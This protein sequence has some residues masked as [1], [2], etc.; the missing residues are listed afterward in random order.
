M[1]KIE[2]VIKIIRHCK[3]YE[4]WFPIKKYKMNFIWI[5]ILM[6]NLQ[7]CLKCT[8]IV[9]ILSNLIWIISVE[10]NGMG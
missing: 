6:L 9:S 5:K 8:S 1:S 10:K 7:Y 3:Y 2:N 4:N